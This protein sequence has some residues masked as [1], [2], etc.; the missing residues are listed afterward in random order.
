MNR[1]NR[2]QGI[3]CIV[4]LVLLVVFGFTVRHLEAGME[5]EVQTSDITFSLSSGFYE[6]EM[7]LRLETGSAGE[8]RYTLDGSSPLADD[9]DVQ[10]YRAKEGIVLACGEQEQLYHVKA[11]CVDGDQVLS[12]EA[13][14]TYVV[15][16]H[17]S[18]RYDMP[19]LS[20]VGDPEEFW[21]EDGILTMENRDW[22]GREA[23][24][25]A[26]TALFDAQGNVVFEQICGVRVFGTATR[27]K[28]QPSLKLY[29]RSEYDE[30][31]RFSCALFED[32]SVDNT[33]I[34]GCKR[35]VVRNGGSDNGYAHLRSE[36][37]SR[38]SMDA[39]FPDAQA[40]SPVCVYINGEY[41]GAYWFVEVFDDSYFEKKYGLYDGEMVV[42]ENNIAYTELLETDDEITL[43]V[44]EQYNALYP[45]LSQL[46]LQ[47]EDNWNYLNDTVDVD[48]F[49]QYMAL[50]NYFCNADAMVNNFKAYRYYSPSGDYREGSVF[51]GRYRFLLF[52]L[53]ETLGFG[54][55][56]E[57]GAEARILSTANR[58]GYDIFYN[59]LFRNIVSTEQGRNRYIKYYLAL[60]NYYCAPE[61]AE[62]ILDEMH[63]SREAELKLQYATTDFMVDNSETPDNIDYRH[64]TRSMNLIREFLEE[65]PD[66][67]LT[68]LEEAFGL[69]SRYQMS[70][71]NAGEAYI[72]IDEIAFSDAA[73]TG[74]FYS[75]VPAILTVQPKC[76]DHFDYWLVDG[77]EYD[78]PVLMIT[79]DMLTDETVYIECVTSKDADAGLLITAV[80][81]RGG[82][83]YVELT[84][85]GDEK[86]NL[87][88]YTI[89]DD[90]DRERASSLPAL[91]VLPGNTITVYCKN[92]T[93]AEAIGQPE[94]NFNVKSGETLYLY[95]KRP[96]QEVPVP[97]LGT[98]DGVYRMDLH[99]GLF[100]ESLH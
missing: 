48:N 35:V 25:A 78:E 5:Q 88:D 56:D 8:I 50:E 51:D 70:V 100:R 99:S 43:E 82:S 36:F 26:D 69:S 55:G 92:Y 15:G 33:L 9:A 75:E 17:V 68:D 53:D 93:G 31:N 13:A 42:V 74:T 37:A 98:R 79:G 97:R 44:K 84:N 12:R 4:C 24:R 57:P 22:R 65:R 81:S 21:G 38:L 2:K 16:A 61:R 7:I 46:D 41:Y 77:R 96:I 1:L 73:F 11:V 87:S 10:V 47:E 95:R 94:V 52:D 34:T 3:L 90:P 71:Q 76:G 80:K 32:Y 72:K 23:E 14:R 86:V 83:D 89:G 63:A 28:N 29:A 6:K 91:E 59:S 49:L 19:V 45:Q 18:D 40:A 27:R 39:G 64:V 85:F 54:M 30:Q 60:L 62:Q 58:V 67:A 66:W 20:V